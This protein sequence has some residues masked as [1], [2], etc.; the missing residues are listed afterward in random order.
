MSD[1][2]HNINP[3]NRMIKILHVIVALLDPNC[4]LKTQRVITQDQIQSVLNT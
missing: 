3:L 2:M 1:K 4:H